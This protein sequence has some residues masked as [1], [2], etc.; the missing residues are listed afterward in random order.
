MIHVIATIK[1]KPGCRD[2]L[3]DV[4]KDFIPQVQAESGCITYTPTMDHDTDIPTQRKE[5]DVVTIVELWE[6]IEAFRAHLIAPH[7]IAYRERVK[8]IVESV[9][10]KVLDHV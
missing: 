2:A 3:I 10:I 5:P 7:V 6:D 8:D 4:Y 1:I 9:S